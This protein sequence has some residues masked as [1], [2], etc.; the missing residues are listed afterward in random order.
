MGSLEKNIIYNMDCLEGLKTLPDNSVDSIITDPPYEL[1]FMEKA[2]DKSGIAYNVELWAECLR[3]LKPGG[4]LLSFGGSRTYHRMVCAIEDAGFEIRDTIMY[5]YGSGMPKGYNIAKGIEGLLTKGSSNTTA[6]KDLSKKNEKKQTIGLN[7]MNYVQDARP[8]N[9]EQGGCFD[10]D[11]TTEEAKNWEG[12]NTT[13]KPAH[14]PIVVARKPISEKNIATNILKWGVGGINIDACRVEHNEKVK[15]TKRNGRKDA[16]VLND[17]SCGFDNTKNV[18]ASADPKGRFP[19]NIILDEVAATMLDEQS[20]ERKA[21]G[22]V[23]GT[24]PSHTGQNGI[25]N[26]YGRVEN[27][28]YGDTGGASRFFYTSKA[29][30]KERGNDNDHPTVKPQ[31]LITYLLKLVTPPN[32]IVL[33]PFM[34]SGTLAVC[35][36]K[37]GNFNYV[38]FER[39]KHYCE[40]AEKRIKEVIEGDNDGSK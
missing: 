1:G 35:C 3:V 10:L 8:A 16:A 36:T 34:G 4:H 15:T 9:Y 38:G 6:F 11:A 5:L 17:E 19:S 25:Y 23:K 29:S 14:E 28:P 27:Q 2:W 39:E 22:K 7:K 37:E 30:K 33:D 20:G 32:G 18:M 26:T 12:W 13:L 24:E 31:A 40:I 21:G